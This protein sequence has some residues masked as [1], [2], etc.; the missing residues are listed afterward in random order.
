MALERTLRPPVQ[1]MDPTPDQPRPVVGCD[2]CAALGKQWLQAM[3]RAG[4]AY[5]PSHAVDLGI[6]ISRH[7]H[8]RE[9]RT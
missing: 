6:E 4:P 9:P 8:Q 3:D 1:L 5:D 2:V 7:P